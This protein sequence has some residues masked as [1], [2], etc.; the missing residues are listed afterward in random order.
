MRFIIPVVSRSVCIHICI[1]T[2]TAHSHFI[3]VH[4]AV[5]NLDLKIRPKT[6][7]KKHLA[8]QR[9]VGDNPEE[10]GEN[11]RRPQSG[12]F[13]PFSS[14]TG[15]KFYTSVALLATLCEGYLMSVHNECAS[16]IQQSMK[17]W[18]SAW[19]ERNDQHPEKHRAG[20]PLSRLFPH[21]KVKPDRKADFQLL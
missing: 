19:K 3:T 20:L 1:H 9:R 13:G 16:C 18:R 4:V 11:P 6:P 15:T 17:Q 2:C 5:R 8:S 12:V 7:P 14:R 21:R 10:K